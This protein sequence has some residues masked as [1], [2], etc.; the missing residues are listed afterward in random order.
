MSAQADAAQAL[1][2]MLADPML[3]DQMGAAFGC[4]E[5]AIITDFL[6]AWGEPEAATIWVDMHAVGD[7]EDD[8][9]YERGREV[10]Q[11]IEGT[12]Y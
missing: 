7:E 12:G 5:I 11:T 4:G 2:E 1:A 3:A 9:H 8:E 6:N 10:A